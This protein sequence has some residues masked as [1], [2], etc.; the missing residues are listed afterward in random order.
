M[1]IYRFDDFV[2][3]IHESAY[4]APTAIIIGDVTI[5]ADCYIGHTAVLRGDYGKIVIGAGS[6]IE[7]A[8]I[9]HARPQDETRIGSRVT[10]GHGAMIH[11]AVIHDEATIGM[12]AVISDFSEVGAGTLVGEQALVKRGQ[13][14]PERVVAVGVPAKVV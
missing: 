7:E 8:V 14:L 11:N 12:C 5:G 13:K 4:V 2:P 3:S 9:I 10:V 1:P 6:A